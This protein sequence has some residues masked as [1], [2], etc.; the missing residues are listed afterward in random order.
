MASA[1]LPLDDRKRI[2]RELTGKLQNAEVAYYL[3]RQKYSQISNE[4]MKE[5]RDPSVP[6]M[7]YRAASEMRMARKRYRRAAKA[8]ASFTVN[9]PLP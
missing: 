4:L 2:E 8:L 7:L 3:E 6:Q 9:G 1:E 5:P